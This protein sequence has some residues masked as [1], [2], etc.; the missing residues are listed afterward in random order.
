VLPTGIGSTSIVDDITEKEM[1]AALVQVG[2]K[3]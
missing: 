2:M 1:K 3:K